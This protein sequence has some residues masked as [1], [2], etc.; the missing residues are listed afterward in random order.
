[1]SFQTVVVDKEKA[2]QEVREL[3]E[4]YNQIVQKGRDIKSKEE[5]MTKKDLILPLF[6]A[7]GWN[8]EDSYEVTA[9]EKISKGWVDYSFRINDIPKF[10]LEAKSIKEDLDN[11][12]F[13][14][15]AV[16]YAFH[17]GC[18]WAVLTNFGMMK[19][20][21][22]EWKAPNYSQSHFMSIGYNEFLDRFDDLWL[23]SKESFEQGLLDKLA[24]RFGK[25]AKRSPIDKQLLSDLTKFRDMLS[26]NITKLNRDRKL[27][28]EELDESVQR[29]L[30]R[31]IFIRNCEDRELEEK[32]LWE[33]RGEAR[34]SKK[35]KEVFAYY[36]KNYDS[37]LFTYDSADAKRVH[38]CDMLD[39]DDGVIR[40]IIECLYRA[41]D[42]S[43]FYNFRIIPAD[44]LGIV[45]EQYL[46][47]ILKK[48]EKTSRLRENHAH[49]KEQGIYY[50]PTYI[51]D[52]I[53]R[54]TLGE[55]LKDK[56]VNVEKIRVLDP[57]CG[58]GSFLI[59]AFD[60][61]NEYCKNTKDYTQTQLDTT[62]TGLTYSKKLGILQNNIFGVDL[63]K[64]AV[65]IAQLNLLLKIAEKGHRLPLLEQNIKCGNS[66]IDDEKVA[67]DKAFKWEEKFKDTMDEGG[68]DVVIG[69]PPYVKLQT[70]D[71]NQ[72]GYFYSNY[73]S[74]KMHYDI[75]ALFVEKGFSLLKEGGILGFILPSKFFIAD[76]GVGLRKLLS[77][78]KSI[79]Q[80]VN[81]KDFQVFDGA[82]TYTCLLLLRKSKN[83]DFEYYEIYDKGKLQQSRVLSRDVFKQSVQKQPEG[84]APWNFSADDTEQLMNK[85]KSNSLKL[86]DVAKD[87]FQGFLSG[88]D[89][90]FFIRVV[91]EKGNNVVV[92]NAYDDREH[93][94][95][96]KILKKL[97]KGKEI[98]RWQ[99]DWNNAFVIYPYREY[100][101]ITSLIPI[102]EIKSDYSKAYEYFL[103][104]KKQL[105]T[106]ETS[107][108][109]DDT[110]YY[111]FRRAR[112]QE[113]F[114][115]RK[116]LTQVLS[117]RN[118]FTIDEMGEFY[119]VG[120]GNA[121]GFGIILKD[122]YAKDYFVILSLL[123]S[124]LLEFHLKRI[125]TPFRGGFYSYGKKFIENLP[126]VIPTRENWD[127][128]N[129]FSNKQ[130]E[131]ARRLNEIGN[132]ATD[133]YA[134][135]EEEIKKTD[136]EIDELVYR[137]Y[138]IT[139]S[140]K[141][142]IEDSLK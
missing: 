31:L 16:N 104:Y 50:T 99:I 78:N 98:K 56:K 9:E 137:I 37:K 66:L 54:N 39:V 49:R 62:G 118:S 91:E 32:K 84:E 3:V 86:G 107:E 80:I 76:Y 60:I 110:N 43:I 14:Q 125:S 73:E 127:R 82:T 58:S 112:S 142:I 38:L 70:L 105:M 106:S 129:E 85:L 12:R 81:F 45:Y 25:R 30:D 133:E 2:K 136:S 1:M 130:L 19:I 100:N 113:Q 46:G 18:T 83:E 128:L 5:E 88:R 103:F 41:K 119:F 135:I 55:L 97:L 35:V 44:I 101:N 140:E 109:V 28:E 120:G 22:A 138:G 6:H 123:N 23:L 21:N 141:K 68:F 17:K 29:I 115:Q 132:K 90:F 20:L 48:T 126:I 15:Q 89:R 67:G 51:V 24:E 102:Q 108:A 87:I 27:T 4:R 111:R 36:N 7:L 26:K 64:Q 134:K 74:A 33:T 8:T 94:I 40:E 79:M 114:E 124:K 69:N 131:R 11:H 71:K 53:V 95:E 117:S 72:I 122:E 93:L 77:E 13:F 42:D 47:H 34:V 121:G 139:E 10:F 61:L 75:Y 52:Y 96:R 65:E 59:K 116:I 63:D 92:K 57:A